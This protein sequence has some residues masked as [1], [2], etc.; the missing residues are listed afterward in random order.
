[1]SRKNIYNI[2]KT[3]KKLTKI[4]QKSHKNSLKVLNAPKK[5]SQKPF[6]WKKK[7]EKKSLKVE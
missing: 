1:L 3:E 4:Q 6:H 7:F 2:K 5:I